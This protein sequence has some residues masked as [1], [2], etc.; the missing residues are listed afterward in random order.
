MSDKGCIATWEEGTD[1]EDG[2]MNGWGG[3]IIESGP[4]VAD[5]YILLHE[6]YTDRRL[7]HYLRRPSI[8][9]AVWQPSRAAAWLWESVRK[10]AIVPLEWIGRAE[11]PRRG[12][13]YGWSQRYSRMVDRWRWAE[14]PSPGTVEIDEDKLDLLWRATAFEELRYDPK[15]EHVV[16]WVGGEMVGAVM[17]LRGGLP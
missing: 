5:G 14:G 17:P 9:A 13:R 16:A 12:Q 7:M 8:T 15:G 3:N 11:H 6:D 1:T 4:Y 2:S 10:A